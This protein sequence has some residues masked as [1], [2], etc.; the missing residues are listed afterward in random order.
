MKKVFKEIGGALFLYLVIFL[1]VVAISSRINYIN[2][3][4]DNQSEVIALK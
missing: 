4:V 2:N 1:G 3:Q